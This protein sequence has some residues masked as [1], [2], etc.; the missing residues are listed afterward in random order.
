MYDILDKVSYKLVSSVFD[1]LM[2]QRRDGTG[3]VNYV[4]ISQVHAFL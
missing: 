2:Q 1:N 4:F 3:P